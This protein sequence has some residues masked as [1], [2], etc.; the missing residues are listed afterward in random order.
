MSTI[1][2]GLLRMPRDICGNDPLAVQQWDAAREDAAD[3]IETLR[4]ERD[5]WRHRFVRLSEE[6]VN[7]RPAQVPCSPE[8]AEPGGGS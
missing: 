6:Y 7:S 3:E 1:L 2:I 8:Q 5:D 4:A